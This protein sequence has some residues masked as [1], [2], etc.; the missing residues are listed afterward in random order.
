MKSNFLQDVPKNNRRLKLNP[1]VVEK[2]NSQ[3][4][5]SYYVPI[6]S[7]YDLNLPHFPQN[8]QE[9]TESGY[10]LLDPQL[11][12]QHMVERYGNYYYT[13][14]D[15]QE[16]LAN[17]PDITLTFSGGECLVGGPKEELEEL[18]GRLLIFKREVEEV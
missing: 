4:T 17:S 6:P 7:Y 8:Y 13:L 1:V 9:G 14:V 11:T 2:E 16:V 5:T 15:L 18:V 3:M 12:V 10:I